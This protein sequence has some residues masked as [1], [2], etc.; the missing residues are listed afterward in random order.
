MPK[1]ITC[2]ANVVWCQVLFLG[3][4][5]NQVHFFCITKTL[6]KG[7]GELLFIVSACLVILCA[8][9]QANGRVFVCEEG[10]LVL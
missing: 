7:A 4:V 6:R 3:W 1:F 10:L 9:W 5:V 8:E 2:Y